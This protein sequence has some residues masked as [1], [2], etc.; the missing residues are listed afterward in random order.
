MISLVGHPSPKKNP[1]AE[2]RLAPSSRLM[3]QNI[4]KIPSF[5]RGELLKLSSV[6]PPDHEEIPEKLNWKWPIMTR[7]KVDVQK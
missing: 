1:H 4:R 3:V 5:L 6:S 7:I 2:N